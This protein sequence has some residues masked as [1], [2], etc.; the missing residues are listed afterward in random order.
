METTPE[1]T[2]LREAY[3]TFAT[4]FGLGIGQAPMQ[5]GGSDANNLAAS[6]VP[7]IDGLG[8]FGKFMHSPR[9]WSDLDSLRRRTQALACFLASPSSQ[10]L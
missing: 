1:N 5:G 8:P 10:N 7:T 9:E 3:E 6:G 4:R 2:R